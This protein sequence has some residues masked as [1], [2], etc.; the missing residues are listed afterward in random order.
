M[1]NIR[2]KKEVKIGK[3]EKLKPIH[4]CVAGV[5][6]GAAELYVC[7]PE[8]RDMKPVR[9]FQTFTGELHRIAAWLKQCGVTSVAMESTGI[10]WIPLYEV[11]E[12]AG[13][14]V[15]VVNAR[16]AKNLP[17]RKSDV[18]DCQW[19]QQ[20]H[21]YGLLGASFRP[22]KEIVALRSLVRH[23][24]RL[25]EGRAVHIQHMQKALRLMNVQL[26]NVLRDITGVTGLRIVRAIAAGQT[27]PEILAGFRDPGCKNSSAVIRRSLEGNFRS[28]HLFPL[29]Q[30]LQLYDYHTEMIQECDR[31][32]ERTYH[33]FDGKADAQT[34]PMPTFKKKQKQ[35]NQPT[36]DL[37]AE[38]YKVAGV[39][40]TAIDGCNAVTIQTVLSETGIDMKPWPTCGHF[41]S[42]LRLCPHNDVSGGRVLKSRTQKT[43]NR[44]NTALRLAAQ[45]LSHS[46]SWLGAYYRRQRA[47]LGPPKAVTAAAHKIARIIYHMLKHGTEFVD[48]GT[49]H[50]EAQYRRRQIRSLEKKAG[51][52][53]LYLVPV[54]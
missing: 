10:Y 50:Y 46:N 14:E 17:G 21:S 39:D 22:S 6:V 37:R 53:G 44:A 42:W 4:P 52:L 45:S 29:K 51:S 41:T 2:R 49:D 8:D 40:L 19:I 30:S 43:A 25:I 18:L 12:E 16:E 24:D 38:L 36:F 31:E 11:L 28:E 32:I 47:R 1:K 35:K 5:D 54:T 34:K 48:F 27:D 7:V 26:D 33:E 9:V 20:L 23:R 15:R 13:F 3:L